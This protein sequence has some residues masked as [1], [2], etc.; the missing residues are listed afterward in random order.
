LQISHGDG[1][2]GKGSEME[3]ASEMEDVKER[4]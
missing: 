1:D 4:K 3:G 2:G